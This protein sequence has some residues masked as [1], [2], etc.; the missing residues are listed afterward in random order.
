MTTTPTLYAPDSI[1]LDNAYAL[2]SVAD[3]A[4]PDFPD[5]PG[6]EFLVSVRDDA[7]ERFDLVDSEDRE[8]TDWTDTA[9]EI[10]DSQVPSHTHEKWLAFV[11]LQAYY[12]DVSE[13]VDDTSDLNHIGGVAL[14][15]IGRRLAVAV[16]ETLSNEDAE[17]YDE[18]GN[19]TWLPVEPEIEWRQTSCVV[20]STDVEGD[21][22]GD[23]WND[24]AGNTR[25]SDGHAHIGADPE[26]GCAES[27]PWGTTCIIAQ[28][29]HD[30][31]HRDMENAVWPNHG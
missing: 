9:H 18:D 24:R 28:R 16:L 6:A 29:E 30:T 17:R 2:A 10:A 27:S 1:R 13:L 4:S 7:V 22:G 19:D 20:C 23:V 21:P 26:N 12:E 5:S 15:E 8:S 14:Y 3:V 11:D 31:D 25:G